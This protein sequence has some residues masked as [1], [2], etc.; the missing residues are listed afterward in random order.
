MFPVTFAR[1][2]G[3]DFI[4]P[5]LKLLPDPGAMEKALATLQDMFLPVI[6]NELLWA[7][8]G[9]AGGTGLLAGQPPARRLRSRE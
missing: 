6:P 5:D 1:A 4:G 2:F 7:L 3:G 9:L 8:V